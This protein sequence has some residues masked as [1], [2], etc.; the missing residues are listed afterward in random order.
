MF[1][2]RQN[3]SKKPP[4]EPIDVESLQLSNRGQQAKTD[5]TWIH[6]ELYCLMQSDRDILLSPAAWL[7]DN[8]VSDAQKLLKKQL[9]VRN[10]FQDPCCGLAYAFQIMSDEFTQVLHNGYDHWLTISTI[11][12]AT[13]EVFVFDSMYASVSTKV[14][15][16]IAALLATQRPSSSAL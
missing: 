10:G 16:Q 12:A 6:N 14:K 11:G 7:N 3:V 2:L 4:S 8:I 13:D 9:P 1:K 15:H 5:K